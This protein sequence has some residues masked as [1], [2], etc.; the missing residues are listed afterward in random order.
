MSRSCLWWKENG[1]ICDK[2]GLT[3]GCA[4]R[5]RDGDLTGR[6]RLDMV[7]AVL[8]TK[9]PRH[10]SV[11]DALHTYSARAAAPFPSKLLAGVSWPEGPDAPVVAVTG[12]CKR[13]KADFYVDNSELWPML[14]KA[15]DRKLR[16]DRRPL[17]DTREQ[18]LV[19]PDPMHAYTRALRFSASELL[20]QIQAQ[21]GA[22]RAEA[23]VAGIDC[24]VDAG[25]DPRSESTA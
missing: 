3:V 11:L 17:P 25:T 24:E 19:W 23:P 7:G 6:L 18:P 4:D 2:C 5:D 9:P 14:R 15:T 1:V 22:D 12:S 20:E 13:C 8:H 16:R 21:G 10:R